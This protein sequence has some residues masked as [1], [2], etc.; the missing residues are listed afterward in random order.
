M[1]TNARRFLD[2]DPVVLVLLLLAIVMESA[3]LIIMWN[4]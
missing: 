3:S 2:Y 1:Q 4:C